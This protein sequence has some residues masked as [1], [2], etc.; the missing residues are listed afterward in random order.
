MTAAASHAP[1]ENAVWRDAPADFPFW[2]ARQ[3]APARP[4]RSPT[5]RR[6][7]T[8]RPSPRVPGTI[9][10][11]E[12]PAIPP[13]AATPSKDGA[14]GLQEAPLASAPRSLP[15]RMPLA[16]GPA[17]P[18]GARDLAQDD[19]VAVN[20]R[21]NGARADAAAEARRRTRAFPLF[22]PPRRAARAPAGA[23]GRR[24]A[25]P[26]LLSKMLGRG[27]LRPPPASVTPPDLSRLERRKP[28]SLPD[29]APVPLRA[30]ELDRIE[31]QDPRRAGTAC[32]RR[33]PH[34]DAGRIWHEGAARG[35]AADARWLWL[36]KEKTRWWAVHE[37]EFNAPLLRHQALWWSR[38]RGVWFA[39]HDGELWSWRRFSEWDAEGLLRLADG[40]EMVYSAD[41][42]KVAVITPGAGAALYDA[43]TGALLGEW[44]ESE[45]P[46]RRPRAPEA[47][48]L[49]RG[50]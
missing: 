27:A 30:Y 32:R 7:P 49:P 37:P 36:W 39:L 24:R 47:L 9:P 1:D 34:W 11:P 48:R 28:L 18:D 4:S 41:F 29:G 42:T 26:L 15:R 12:D 25:R 19:G 6:G 3:A 13:Q 22:S 17:F 20:A 10:V 21:P 44:L 8:P 31:A 23:P 5:A 16:R 50:I 43:G 40:V 35:V 46:R 33:A 14:L 2:A 45:L 38:Q